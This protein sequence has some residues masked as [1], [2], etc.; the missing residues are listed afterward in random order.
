MGNDQPSRGACLGLRAPLLTL[1]FPFI[2]C[3]SPYA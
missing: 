3:H 1:H 2:A